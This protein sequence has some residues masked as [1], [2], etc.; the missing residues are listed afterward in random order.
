MNDHL[1]GALYTGLLNLIGESMPY[2]ILQKPIKSW[3]EID[4]RRRCIEWAK[5][6]VEACEELLGFDPVVDGLS[7]ED[8]FGTFS[9]CVHAAEVFVN[10][11]ETLNA[12]P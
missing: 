10:L 4:R 6:Y 5:E 3:D 2:S 8:D 11:A 12:S 7:P 1:S 9:K